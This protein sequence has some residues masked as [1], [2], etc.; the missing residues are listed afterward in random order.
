M[1]TLRVGNKAGTLSI[2]KSKRMYTSEM[3]SVSASA[4]DSGSATGSDNGGGSGP[5]SD[6]GDKVETDS[7]SSIASL[8]D[9]A[10]AADKNA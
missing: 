1:V 3:S 8:L 9:A 2:L 5:G 10:R 6:I 4:S 7:H